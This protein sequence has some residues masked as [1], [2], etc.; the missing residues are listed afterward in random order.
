MVQ[1]LQ[2]QDLT[3]RCDGKAILLIIEFQKFERTKV[4]IMLQSLIIL[5]HFNVIL[6]RSVLSFD[7]D[8]TCI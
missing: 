5:R 7:L 2:N 1:L 8:L 3:Q 4:L 6:T